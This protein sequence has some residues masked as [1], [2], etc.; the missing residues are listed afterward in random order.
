MARRARR[1]DQERAQLG[2][3]KA[4]SSA[5]SRRV[6]GPMVEQMA[7]L[8][9]SLPLQPVGRFFSMVSQMAARFFDRS[10]SEKSDLPMG[11]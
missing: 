10:P 2:E 5:R 1:S 7:A 4:L 3:A 11:T 6:A 8:F 9:H